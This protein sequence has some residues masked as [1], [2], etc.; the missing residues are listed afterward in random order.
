[1]SEATKDPRK[2]RILVPIDFSEGSRAAFERA[3]ELARALDG[4]IV[5]LNAVD[6][7]GLYVAAIEP[8]LD[9]GSLA[10]QIRNSAKEE[11]AKFAAA[12]EGAEGRIAWTEVVDGRPIEAILQRAREIHADLIVMGTHGRTGVSRLFLGSVAERVTRSATCDV[13]VVHGPKAAQ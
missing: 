13:M 10:I 4:E 6:A 8:L 12:V 1:M 2:R 3:L 9:V 5:L 11:L 7:S